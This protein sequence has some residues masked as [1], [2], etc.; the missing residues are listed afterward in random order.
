MSNSKTYLR[1][2]AVARA[3]KVPDQKINALR[4]S[5]GLSL[6]DFLLPHALL[7]ILLARGYESPF[8]RDLSNKANRIAILERLVSELEGVRP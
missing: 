5:F 1:Q 6:N 2:S 7:D 8:R 4:K 3:Y